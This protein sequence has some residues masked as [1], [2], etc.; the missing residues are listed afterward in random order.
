MLG[1]NLSY[2]EASIT[3]PKTNAEG[4][5]PE[6]QEAIRI[7]GRVSFKVNYQYESPI[8]HIQ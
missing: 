2:I 3:T 4:S 5:E 1:C 6:K 7:K 8:F